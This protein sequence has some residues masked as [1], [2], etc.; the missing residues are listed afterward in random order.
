MRESAKSICRRA[1]SEVELAALHLTL[2]F[3]IKNRNLRI[4]P[5]LQDFLLNLFVD[6]LLILLNLLNVFIFERLVV[7]LREF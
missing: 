6:L 4:V 2:I 7:V 3:T 1:I 5:P